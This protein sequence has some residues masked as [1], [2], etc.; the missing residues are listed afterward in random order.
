MLWALSAILHHGI[1]LMRGMRPHTPFLSFTF[2]LP[3]QRNCILWPNNLLNLFVTCFDIRIRSCCQAGKLGKPVPPNPSPRPL[4]VLEGTTKTFNLT[5]TAWSSTGGSK[6]SFRSFPHRAGR[7]TA[8]HDAQL[9]EEREEGV[10]RCK[11]QHSCWGSQHP[12]RHRSTF[13]EGDGDHLLP[14]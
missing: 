12:N 14:C 6:T 7:R 5:L 2:F 4:L 3:P 9:L 11:G 8:G 13:T 1:W 10:T